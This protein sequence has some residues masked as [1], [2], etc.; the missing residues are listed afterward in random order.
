MVKKLIR[1]FCREYAEY[2]FEEDY[3]AKNGELDHCIGISLAK[4]GSY[5]E[6]L[7]DL[8]EYLDQQHY[9]NDALE[10]LAN[11]EVEELEDRMIICFPF[12]KRMEK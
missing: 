4:D 1:Q 5:M 12:V 10:E 3:C 2:S 6:A 11:P 7:M 9:Y 8:T